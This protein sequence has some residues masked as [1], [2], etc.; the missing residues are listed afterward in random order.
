M[1]API[2][3]FGMH[4]SGTSLLAQLLQ[5]LGLFLGA[6]K[7]KH[8]ESVFFVGI[9]QGIM[10]E[11]GASW[12]NPLPLDSVLQNKENLPVVQEYILPMLSSLESITYLGEENSQK[13]TTLFDLEIPWGWKDPRNTFTLPVWLSIFP[14]A[15]VIYIERHGTDVAQSLKSRHERGKSPS[16]RCN[17]LEGAFSLWEEYID[18]GRFHIHSL[19]PEKSLF[20]G[21]EDL[22]QN[23]AR[24]LPK[25]A[26]FCNLPFSQTK[27]KKLVQDINT[28][29]A[30][31]Y[32]DSTTL[33]KF[34]RAVSNRLRGYSAC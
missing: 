8:H 10:Q 25:I 20:I 32:K 14:N 29:R 13:H 5:E 6:K 16:S 24:H 21:F 18:R 26:R 7:E 33:L 4:R 22:V 2:I 12:D 3:I 28:T 31:A 27:V 1:G 17:S 9:N 15:K 34:S 30:Y 11:L 19:P 23:G